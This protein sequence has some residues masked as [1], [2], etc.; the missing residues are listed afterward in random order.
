M[1]L[2]ELERALLRDHDL[3]GSELVLQELRRTIRAT[4]QPMPR[5]GDAARRFYVPLEPFLIDGAA[6]HK[7]AGRLARA[8]LEPLWDWIG[9]DLMPAEAKALIGDINRALVAED[10]AK[11]EQVVR[12]LHECA[13]QR[14]GAAIGSLEGGDKARRRFSVQVGT[15]RALEDVT[16]LMH[17]L[18]LRDA[19]A[20]L[21]RRLPD[22]YRTFEPEDAAEVK[23]LLE[24]LSTQRASQPASAQRSDF[25]L[26]GM[27]IVADR[28]ATPW[29]LIRLA[30]SAAESDDTSRIAATPYAAAV[31]IVLSD[32]EHAVGE[33]R[34][35][36]KSGRPVGW[37]LKSIHDAAR[38]MRTEMNLSVDS[39]WSRQLAA[40]RTGV[41]NLL[42]GEIQTT[43]GRVRRLLRPRRASEIPAGL[44]LDPIDVQEVEMLVELVE[45]CRHYAGELAVSEVTL[46][47]RSELT[48]YL[49]TGTR[50][51]VD[52][53]R[54]AEDA[55]RPFRRSQIEAAVRFCRA[56]FGADYAELLAKAAEVAL[57]AG[58]ADRRSA[59]A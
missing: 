1:L 18:A 36:L 27:I 38:T 17:V 47:T 45:A 2:G 7:R 28:M 42:A 25:L 8:A 20:E 40:I 55:E 49:E 35:E 56:V 57:Q 10:L 9:R 23:T 30:T 26:Y 21:A 15:P 46:R 51:L 3:G 34:S 59:R 12:V 44:Q 58:A 43:P 53:L 16:M 13:I 39:A 22:H 33:L 31:T 50:V 41:S 29:Q 48:Q 32:L 4:A 52:A 6:D 11:V 54:Q 14:I 24:G 5:I 37:L 19:L